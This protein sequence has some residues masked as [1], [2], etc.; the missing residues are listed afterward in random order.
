M[1]VLRLIV[2]LLTVVLLSLSELDTEKNPIHPCKDSI[3]PISYFAE[4]CLYA[5]MGSAFLFLPW[6]WFVE[7]VCIFCDRCPPNTINSFYDLSLRMT[8]APVFASAMPDQK[9]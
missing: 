6:M 8:R 9:K 5:L 4:S 3:I 2:C 7:I 1:Q